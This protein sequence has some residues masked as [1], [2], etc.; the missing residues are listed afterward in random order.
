MILWKGISFFKFWL[1]IG[2]ETQL[3]R[4]H[5]CKHYPLKHWK[6]SDMDIARDVIL[7]DPHNDTTP[8]TSAAAASTSS[9]TF[10]CRSIMTVRT[11]NR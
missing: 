6:L 5:E 2:R 8:M 1:V 11:K 10:S 4:F 7:K 9:V 3:E